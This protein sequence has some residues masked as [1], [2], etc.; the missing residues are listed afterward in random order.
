MSRT[1]LI[2]LQTLPAKLFKRPAHP[3]AAMSSLCPPKALLTGDG[4][5]RRCGGRRRSSLP[6]SGCA[7]AVSGWVM[8][9]SLR[10]KAGVSAAVVMVPR[11][12]RNAAG[13]VLYSQRMGTVGSREE[14]GGVLGGSGSGRWW[15]SGRL[16]ACTFQIVVAKLLVDLRCFAL[17][18]CA[19]PQLGYGLLP[20]SHTSATARGTWSHYFR[21]LCSSL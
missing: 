10:A 8:T 14:G 5:W 19:A 7:R 13:M 11:A 12:R 1:R 9:N 4:T 21:L 2:R 16:V 6:G 18:G 17:S 20:S 15:K 3:R